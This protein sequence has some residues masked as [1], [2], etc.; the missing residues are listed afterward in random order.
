MGETKSFGDLQIEI[1]DDHV[2]LAEIHDALGDPRQQPNG[3]VVEA[4]A[5]PA[6]HD[7]MAHVQ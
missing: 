2:A 6:D 3:D 7:E 1:G 5:R 4:M